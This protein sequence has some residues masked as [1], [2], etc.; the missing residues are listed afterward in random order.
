MK[1]GVL[2][3]LFSDKRFEEALDYVKK[4]GCDAVEIGAANYAKSPHCNPDELLANPAKV[5]KFK[6]M[7]VERGLVISALSCHGNPLHPDK[8]VAEDYIAG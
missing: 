3:T 4:V 6:E 8:K 2:M 7:V 5:R 1:L